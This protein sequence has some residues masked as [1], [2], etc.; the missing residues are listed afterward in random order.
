[1]KVI[2]G[3]YVL[4]GSN[5]EDRGKNLQQAREHIVQQV[6]S[7]IRTSGIYETEAW[8][9]L[10]QPLFYNQVIQIDTDL[11]HEDLLR[12][13]QNI[14]QKIGKVKVGKWRERLIDIDL[15]YYGNRLVRTATLTVPHPEI[16]NRRFT[17]APLVELIPNEVHPVLLQSHQ[18][19]L[20]ATPDTLEVWLVGSRNRVGGR[21]EAGDRK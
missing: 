12:A 20:A 13:L 17:L 2:K 21:P 6:G 16:Q 11:G 14:E 9:V 5:L 8:G 10:D 15:L 18:K 3:I 7:I 19:L 4:L 1:M